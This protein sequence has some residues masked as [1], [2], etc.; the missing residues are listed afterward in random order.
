MGHDQSNTIGAVANNNL[1]A[2]YVNHQ[3]ITSITDNNYSEGQIGVF[4]D[5]DTHSTEVTFSNAKVWI[6]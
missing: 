6:P 2:V 5:N 1:I 3:L 4:A